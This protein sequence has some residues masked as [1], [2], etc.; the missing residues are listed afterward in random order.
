MTFSGM[1]AEEWPASFVHDEMQRST[2]LPNDKCHKMIA[3][4]QVGIVTLELSQKQSINAIEHI[5][6]L[7]FSLNHSKYLLNMWNIYY[8]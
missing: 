8:L 7:I 3:F 2:V 6:P 5:Y 4:V 1:H